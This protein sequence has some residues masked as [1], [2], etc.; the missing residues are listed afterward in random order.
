MGLQGIH[1]EQTAYEGFYIPPALNTADYLQPGGIG[2]GYKMKSIP[3]PQKFLKKTAGYIINT[4]LIKT[5]HA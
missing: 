3:D 1:K 2:K 4:V 5:A